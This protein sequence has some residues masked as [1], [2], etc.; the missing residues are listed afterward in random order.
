MNLF[1]RFV[2]MLFLQLVAGMVALTKQSL[3]VLD[4]K[5]EKYRLKNCTLVKDIKKLSFSPYH[6]GLTVVN[7]QPQVSV[8]LT[9]T[10]VVNSSSA[11]EC[12]ENSVSPKLVPT[13]FFL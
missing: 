7:A 13:L 2:M 1:H 5:D 6:D 12:V 10:H 9:C 8:L 3:I 4:E 11:T